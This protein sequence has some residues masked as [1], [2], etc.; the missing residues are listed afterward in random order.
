MAIVGGGGIVRTL[1]TARRASMVLA[2]VSLACSL[3]WGQQD[4]RP[5]RASTKVYFDTSHTADALLRSAD[6]HGKA[7]SFAEAVDIYQRV[8]RPV[9]R[10]GRRGPARPGRRGAQGGLATLGQRPPRV[11][12]ADRRHAR[13]TPGRSTGPGSTPRPSDGSARDRPARGIGRLFGGSSTRRSARRG[14]TTR[15]S[16]WATWH[17]RTASSPRRSRPMP[18]S[19]RIA[20]RPA[21]GW[22]IPTPASTW[23]RVAARKLLCRAAIGDHPADRGRARGV[24][25][26]EY[27]KPPPGRS[28]G[29]SGGLAARPR[30]KPFATTI[31]PPRPRPTTAGPPSPGPP[32]RSKVAPGLG[33]RRLAPVEDRAR[34]GRPLALERGPEPDG[35]RGWECGMGMGGVGSAPP[36]RS[37]PERLLAYHPIVVG[38]QVLIVNDKQV[39]APTTSAV[40]P[41]DQ[42]GGIDLDPG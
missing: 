35:D 40:R 16:C 2:G 42:Q 29:A 21:W 15:W 38:D 6:N 7:G 18:S 17:S 23:S 39:T 12:A 8:I 3:S 37:L 28:P 31:S 9:R 14:G 41:G 24:R 20:P 33:R 32:A 34:V 36:C 13:R 26:G 27:P 19:C 4:F 11:P 25:Q 5:I 10:Q 1:D 22:S 30:S